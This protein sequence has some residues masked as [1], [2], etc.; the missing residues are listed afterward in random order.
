MAKIYK[1]AGYYL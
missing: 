1:A